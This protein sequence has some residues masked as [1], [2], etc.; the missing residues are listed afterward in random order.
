MIDN[1]HAQKL[2]FMSIAME[3]SDPAQS[4]KL[5]KSQAKKCISVLHASRWN[6]QLE[7]LEVQSKFKDIISLESDCPIWNRIVL[8]LPSGQLSF[9]LRA[10]S[11]TLPTPLNLCRWK[12][13]TNPRCPLCNSRSPTALHI[14]NGCPVA[15]NQGRYTWRHDSVLSCL[16]PNLEN[17]QRLYADL[18]GHRASDSP[19]LHHPT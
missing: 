14:L 7:R 3:L 19:P 9:I 15:L 12:I 11:D 1:V 5:L 4:S 17:D 2:H 13:Q 10:G 6:N 16:S 8:G 18:P